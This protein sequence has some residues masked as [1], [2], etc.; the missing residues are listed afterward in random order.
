MQEGKAQYEKPRVSDHANQEQPRI[1][2]LQQ[3]EAL[4]FKMFDVLNG[5]NYSLTALVVR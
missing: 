2:R 5:A 3:R 1:I 4:M